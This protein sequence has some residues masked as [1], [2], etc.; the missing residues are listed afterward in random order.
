[1]KSVNFILGIVAGVLAILLLMSKC[2][3]S[4]MQKQVN[5][6]VKH[7]NDLVNSNTNDSVTI[8]SLTTVSTIDTIVK[9]KYITKTRI[10]PAIR[11][12]VRLVHIDTANYE[13][14]PYNYVN[15]SGNVVVTDSLLVEGKIISHKQ[16][17]YTTC[18]DTVITKEVIKYV[19]SPSNPQK[20]SDKFAVWAGIRSDYTLLV[21]PVI[22]FAYKDF[23]LSFAKGIN[24][25]NDATLQLQAKIRFK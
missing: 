25:R 3:N 5:D 24:N 12:T 9:V 22:S 14:Q 10:L 18:K 8:D 6:L 19:A 15:Q 23:M 7:N 11:D 16:D 21:Q 1:M 20:Q 2:D 4:K 13:V 17:I